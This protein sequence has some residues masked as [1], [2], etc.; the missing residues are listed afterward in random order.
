MATPWLEDHEIDSLCQPLVQNAAKVRHL[1]DMG[2]VVTTRPNGRPVVLRES[3]E[4][5][6]RGIR[7]A[8]AAGKP[9]ARQPV[10]PNAA[11]LVL[12]FSRR[13]A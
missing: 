3:W 5:M 10:G 4:A 2:L 1:R 7:A 9:A 12:Q 11:G 6:Q 13:G 8:E